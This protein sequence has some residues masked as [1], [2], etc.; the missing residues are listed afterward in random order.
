MLP[1]CHV[2]LNRMP[3][4]L[5]DAG[6]GFSSMYLRFIGILL[7]VVS[8][9]I[10]ASFVIPCGIAMNSIVFGIWVQHHFSMHDHF[11]LYGEAPHH[12]IESAPFRWNAALGLIFFV[13]VTGKSFIAVRMVQHL[14]AVGRI[15]QGAKMPWWAQSPTLQYVHNSVSMGIS[16][17]LVAWAGSLA[18]IIA[19][20]KVAG[21]DKR[22]FQFYVAPKVKADAKAQ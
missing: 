6:G 3:K 4:H 10:R 5:R 7:H 21:W 12:F 15:G 20:F 1:V 9:H 2:K 14:V 8:V 16:L 17:P 22:S 11:P 18:E 19:I 13:I